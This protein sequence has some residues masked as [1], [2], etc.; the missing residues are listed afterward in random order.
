MKGASSSNPIGVHWKR[1]VF[2]SSSMKW[3]SSPRIAL[4]LL[5]PLFVWYANHASS[6]AVVIT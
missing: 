5:L 2:D 3:M 1:L 6:S 4:M